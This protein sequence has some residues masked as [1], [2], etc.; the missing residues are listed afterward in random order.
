MMAGLKV[1]L[2][3]EAALAATPDAVR[4]ARCVIQVRCGCGHQSMLSCYRLADR[5]LGS[6]PIGVLAERMVCPNRCAGPPA[7]ETIDPYRSALDPD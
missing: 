1:V 5:G 6:T 3:G 4:A 7:I 2:A